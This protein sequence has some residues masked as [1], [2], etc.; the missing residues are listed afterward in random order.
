MTLPPGL[1]TFV[2]ATHVTSTVGWFGTAAGFFALASAG[3][4]IF[5]MLG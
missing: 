3:L 4:T 5:R 1:R 2:L